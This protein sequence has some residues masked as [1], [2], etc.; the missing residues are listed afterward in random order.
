[1]TDAQSHAFA[2]ASGNADPAVLNHLFVGALIGL[3]LLWAGWGLV[4]VYRGYA[5]G[6]VTEP[7]M[8]RFVI[9]VVVLLTLTLF[10]FAR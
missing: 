6:R 3:L 5:A 4:H 1:M 8:V 10:M 7:L 9:R 2:A